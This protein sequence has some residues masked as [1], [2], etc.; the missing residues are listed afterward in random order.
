[1]TARGGVLQGPRPIGALVPSVTRPAYR[2]HSPAAAQ[3][4]ADWPL[5]VGPRIAAITAPRRLDRG[6]LTIGCSG[7]AAMDLHYV[8]S[9]LIRRIN[10]HVGPGKGAPAVTALRFTQAG[11]PPR[12][13][14]ARQ[15]PPEAVAEAEAAVADLPEGDLRSALA[16]L[17]RVVLGRDRQRAGLRQRGSRLQHNAL[18]GKPDPGRP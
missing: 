11:M 16:A 17:G 10:A 6:T 18:A 12:S 5:I 14:P 7:P 9:E 4:M 1:M 13:A 8:G 2:R 15:P 3:I